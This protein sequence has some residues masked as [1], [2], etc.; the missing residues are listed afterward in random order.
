M[1]IQDVMRVAVRG[2]VHGQQTINTF[3]YEQSAGAGV[4][5]EAQATNLA[6]GI[7]AATWWG[8]YIDLHSNEWSATKFDI[9]KV[10]R[11]PPAVQLSPTYEVDIVDNDGDYVGE[12][13]PTS[14][15]LVVKRKT[16]FG[17]RRGR[18]R[19]FLT[20]VPLDWEDDS[21]ID[22]TDV[23]F[24]AA[25]TALLANLNAT[26]TN[27]TIEWQPR[28]YMPSHPTVLAGPIRVWAYDPILRNQRRRQVG[29]GI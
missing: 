16:D 13:L 8:A 23:N 18:G 17:G 26:V 20:G 29:V 14:I 4:E 12:S 6:N 21:R 25:M 9:A 1:A 19:I 7:L 22:T 11:T 15:A 5:G 2:V 3:Y 28:H 24:D 27:A 10:A